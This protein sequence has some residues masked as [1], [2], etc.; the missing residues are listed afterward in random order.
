MIAAGCSSVKDLSSS[1]FNNDIF[2]IKGVSNCKESHS[3]DA[4]DSQI[5]NITCDEAN[6]FYDYGKFGARGPQS[7]I[8]GFRD[9]FDA[10]Y[11]AKFFDLVHIDTKVRPIFKDS[12]IVTGVMDN[13]GSHDLL[14]D[15][16]TC[17]KVAALL[18]KKHTFYYPFDIK[19]SDSNDLQIVDDNGQRI[20]LYTNFEK[21]LAAKVSW[22]PD[23]RNS[24]YLAISVKGSKVPKSELESLLSSIRLVK[25]PN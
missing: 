8:E 9:A 6:F 19:A 7:D 21:Q 4:V 5:G 23:R 10:V 12:V 25:S 11:Y 24:D 22:L 2:S 15:C 13:S 18:F 14:F 3:G 17:S 1:G 20:K 16:K